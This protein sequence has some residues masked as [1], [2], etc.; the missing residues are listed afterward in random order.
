[1]DTQSTEKETRNLWLLAVGGMF[2]VSGLLYLA[3]I[4]TRSDLDELWALVALPLVLAS[5]TQARR[6]YVKMGKFSG[7]VVGWILIGLSMAVITLAYIFGLDG[8]GLWAAFFIS[9]GAGAILAA[10]R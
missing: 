7:K 8:D 5:F 3:D 6:D 10:W 4:A 9:I 1:M 2:F